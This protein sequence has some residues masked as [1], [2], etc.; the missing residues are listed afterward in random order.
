MLTAMLDVF[1]LG[2]PEMDV[3]HEEFAHLA[4]EVAHAGDEDFANLFDIL[5]DHT[6]R[7][8]DSENRLMRQYGFP[9]VAEHEGE[10]RR[11][12][13]EL[14]HMRRA[15]DE[16]RARLARLYVSQGLPDWFRNH[17]ATMDAAL[18]ARVKRGR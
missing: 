13:G 17:Q 1:V 3:T 11:V 14:G 5:L 12:L 16:G 10:H 8:F 9:A 18:A 7:H 6:Q 4:R 2:V 15:I